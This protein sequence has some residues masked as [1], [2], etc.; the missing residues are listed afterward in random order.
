MGNLVTNGPVVAI[1]WNVNL[2]LKKIF[3]LCFIYK[4]WPWV[5]L[6]PSSFSWD[7]E[8]PKPQDIPQ[9]FH[10]Q[11]AGSSQE[12]LHTSWSQCPVGNMNVLHKKTFYRQHFP[13]QKFIT[14]IIK[15]LLTIVKP[16]SQFPSS[17]NHRSSNKYKTQSKGWEL[18]NR[19]KQEPPCATYIECLNG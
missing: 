5:W 4:V 18:Q 6:R 1:I 3:K 17:N 7:L 8:V 11:W 19:Y 2:Y 9:S 13:H 16:R 10:S 12:F 14:L 15:L